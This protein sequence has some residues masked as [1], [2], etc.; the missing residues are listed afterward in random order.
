MTSPGL[1]AL[2]VVATPANPTAY[3]LY[4]A[5]TVLTLDD[6]ARLLGGVSVDQLNTSGA[7]GRWP[8]ECVP[9]PVPEPMGGDRHGYLE[10]PATVVW[11]TDDCHLP[12][13]TA[14]EA[15]TRA[16]QT[17][18]IT[19]SLDVEEHTAELLADRAGA[20]VAVAGTGQDAV[21]AAVGVIEGQLAATGILGVIHAP[22]S[23]AAALKPWIVER[24]GRMTSPLGNTWAF[25]GGGQ[26]TLEGLIIG[27][28]PVTIR[29][30]SVTVGTG[31]HLP[32]NRRLVVAEREVVVSWEATT[33][34]VA[35]V[36][37]P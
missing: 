1:P 28:G 29:R 3:G 24:S 30:A 12:G 4:A 21:R 22:A 16:I 17:L 20:P 36:E 9:D 5:A 33:V 2:H 15:E 14:A 8:V 35:A 7:H 11:A 32:L 31:L 13:Q 6:P 26:D 23:M 19:E 25:Y 37:V 18:R 10:Y 34:A 27:T